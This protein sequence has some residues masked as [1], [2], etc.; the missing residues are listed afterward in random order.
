MPRIVRLRAFRIFDPSKGPT[1][2]LTNLPQVVPS[3]AVLALM[4]L[5]WSI[6]RA[7]LDLKSH[8]NL[9][10]ARTKSRF[11]AQSMVWA[12][13]ITALVKL[14]TIRCAE[15]LYNR[16][17]SLRRCHKLDQYDQELPSWAVSV[18]TSVFGRAL[19][20]ISFTFTEVLHRLGCS[21]H[22]GACRP[23]AKNRR[24]ALAH[25]LAVLIFELGG[26]ESKETLLL[27][28]KP[29]PKCA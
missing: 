20:G 24:R 18:I 2:V 25:H 5:R 10:G 14:V 19:P 27:P 16:S 21:K 11:L 29:M 9:R 22:T 28:Y 4:R 13:L 26:N 17:L 8:N 15:L 23:S 6:E 12:S 7:F 1:W 3:R